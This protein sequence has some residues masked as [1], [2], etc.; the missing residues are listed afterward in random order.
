MIVFAR[1][2]HFLV[3]PGTDHAMARALKDK[4]PGL[5]KSRVS[6]SAKDKGHQINASCCVENL[7]R[8]ET[9]RDTSSVYESRRYKKNVDL[10]IRKS[11]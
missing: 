7:S 9:A 4:P 5:H 3:I 2:C 10:A 11:R 6:A 1:G 8:I